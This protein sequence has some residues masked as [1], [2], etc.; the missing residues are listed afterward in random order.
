MTQDEVTVLELA[1]V[2]E[3]FDDYQLYAKKTAIYPSPVIYPALGLAGETGEVCEKI[4]K[5]IRDADGDFTDEEFQKNIKKE[6]GDVLWYVANLSSDLGISLANVAETNLVK[7][8]DRKK[9]NVIGGSGDN[10]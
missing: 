4:K 5:R 9:R 10:R 8:Y 3:K 1:L 2:A 6:L 7:L